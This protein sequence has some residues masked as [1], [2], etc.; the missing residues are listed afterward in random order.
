MKE[1]G[2]TVKSCSYEMKWRKC[3]LLSDVAINRRE[4]PLI[5]ASAV[6]VL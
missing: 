1:T 3:T 5:K 2:E 6:G 4:K